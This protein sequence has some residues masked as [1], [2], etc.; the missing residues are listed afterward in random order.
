MSKCLRVFAV[1]LIIFCWSAMAAGKTPHN[2][3]SGEGGSGSDQR[4]VQWLYDSPLTVHEE[5]V[6]LGGGVYEYSFNFENV[7][8]AYLWHFGVYTTFPIIEATATWD[9][10]PLWSMG[11]GS[12]ETMTPEYDAR[13]LDPNIT[14]C[15]NTWGPDW[16]QSTD[17]LVPGE[18]VSGFSFTANTLD[19]TSKFYFYETASSGWAYETGYLAA[20]GLT[21]PGPTSVDETTW[22]QVKALYR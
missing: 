1:V 21:Q 19:V 8:D 11:I 10:H 9:G 16:P 3:V 15:A 18:L 4:S 13:N 5:V 7:D 12:V 2:P 17:P 14:M 22:S 6:D 20:I